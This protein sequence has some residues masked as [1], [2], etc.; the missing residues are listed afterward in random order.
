MAERLKYSVPKNYEI[1]EFNGLKG[2]VRAG[3]KGEK[4]IWEPIY[5]YLLVSKTF[6]KIMVAH[7]SAM[8]AEEFLTISFY[9]GEQAIKAKVYDVLF[10]EN[11][12]YIKTEKSTGDIEWCKV[13]E[14]LQGGLF[15]GDFDIPY[16][17][18]KMP[19]H[20]PIGV[21]SIP[22]RVNGV[23]KKLMLHTGTIEDVIPITS[24]AKP[25]EEVITHY[26]IAINYNNNSLQLLHPVTNKAL[27]QSNSIGEIEAYED[28]LKAMIGGFENVPKER[29]DRLVQI[30][31]EFEYYGNAIAVPVLFEYVKSRNNGDID[32]IL[33]CILAEL[34]TGWKDIGESY[35]AKA[36]ASGSIVIVLVKN[37]YNKI[38]VAPYMINGEDGIFEVQEVESLVNAYKSTKTKT[39]YL[40]IK[41]AELNETIDDEDETSEWPSPYS[42]R[43]RE[44]AAS[45]V[46]EFK[47]KE[48][49]IYYLGCNI[50][51]ADKNNYGDI[52]IN[53]AICDSFTYKSK[54]RPGGRIG[55]WI[56]TNIYAAK[57]V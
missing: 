10:G 3:K 40:D 25:V 54:K 24:K 56:T 46:R 38:I 20:I 42:I 12:L 52:G 48:I 18:R 34:R 29:A 30:L 2:I 17:D 28:I 27:G 16:R 37:K 13:R 41:E 4:W 53:L 15:I 32:A 19:F 44:A 49:N 26:N 1:R 39:V 55:D 50:I 33:D 43:Q 57:I 9:G 23:D 11:F 6:G 8:T 45:D 35:K 14:D 36:Y 31:G 51:G 22:I 5:K 7:L 21:D 47:Y